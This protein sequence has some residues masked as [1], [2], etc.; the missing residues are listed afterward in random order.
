MMCDPMHGNTY[1]LGK[2]KVRNLDD[3]IS[4]IKSAQRIHHDF[5]HP[6][7]GIHLETTPDNI[8]ECL[9]EQQNKINYQSLCDPRLNTQQSIKV[10]T[11][12]YSK[13]TNI[14]TASPS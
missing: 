9:D 14:L 5:N 10:C 2:T 6:L 8:Q 1:T 3:I 12:I 13:I 11:N 7:Q 4:E